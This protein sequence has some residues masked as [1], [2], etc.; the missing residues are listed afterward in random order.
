MGENEN[1]IR[2]VENVGKLL[3]SILSD[4]YGYEITIEFGVSECEE[5][6]M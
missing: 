5:K 3:S 6:A 1:S 4:K 2:I